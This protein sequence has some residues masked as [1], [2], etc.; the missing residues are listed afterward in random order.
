MIS[1]SVI[2]ISQARAVAICAIWCDREALGWG[3][4]GLGPE[5]GLDVRFVLLLQR[6]LKRLSR[7]TSVG[8]DP[9]VPLLPRWRPRTSRRI[10]C[11]HDCEPRP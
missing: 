4:W 10:G 1:A 5:L 9:V 2:P 3:I 8:K 11:P 7:A 6:S